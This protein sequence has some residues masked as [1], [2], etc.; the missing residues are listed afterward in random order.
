MIIKEWKANFNMKQDMLR[1]IPIWIKLPKLPLYLWGER[2][3]DKIGSAIGVPMITDECTT[4]KLRVTYARILVEVDI[5]RKLL[6]EIALKDKD[7]NILLQPIEYEWRPKFCD[8]CHKVGHTCVDGLKKKIWKPRQP[9]ITPTQAEISEESHVQSEELTA[10]VQTAQ[11]EQPILEPVTTPVN[12]D[13]ALL[14]TPNNT[15]QKTKETVEAT[16]IKAK[17]SSKA[18]NKSAVSANSSF[19]THENGFRVLEVLNGPN[20]FDRGP[21]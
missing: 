14:A 20:T 7:G 21:C 2:T 1:T 9:K 18:K 4:H 3:L 8:K 5:T 12:T 17:G 15:K 6:G 19:V 13:G 16:W 10:G 11:A